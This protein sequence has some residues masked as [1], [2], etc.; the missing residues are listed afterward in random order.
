MDLVRLK[1]ILLGKNKCDAFFY[2]LELVSVG[3]SESN[4][5][6]KFALRIII[7]FIAKNMYES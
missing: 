7:G 4:Y 3:T 1:K 2:T 6:G 5:N